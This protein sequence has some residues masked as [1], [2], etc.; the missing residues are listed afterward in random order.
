MVATRKVLSLLDYDARVRVVSPVISDEL[1]ALSLHG[2][3]ETVFRG[4]EEG[5]LAGAL[6]VFAATDDPGVQASVLH[7]AQ[8]EGALFN[9]A[10]DPENC[11]FQ[12]PAYIRR[13]D[14]QISVSTGGASPAFSRMVRRKIEHDFGIEYGNMSILM[15]IVRQKILA[16]GAS[17]Q[18]NRTI[19]RSLVSGELLEAI[20]DGNINDVR[21]IL[22]ESLPQEVDIEAV[23]Q[24]YTG[25]SLA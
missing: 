9:S 15:S 10:D 8:L 25:R 18:E 21:C 11:D 5:D 12:L 22:T 13:G 24:E 6:C 14:F 1:Q 17:S 2:Q 4:Y 20:K 7:D 23:V 16:L 19:F 3:I